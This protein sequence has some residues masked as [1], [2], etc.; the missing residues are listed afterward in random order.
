MTI[1][2]NG[3]GH[4]YNRAQHTHRERKRE[5]ARKWAKDRKN[6]MQKRTYQKNNTQRQKDVRGWCW[7]CVSGFFLN[8]IVYGVC[9][10]VHGARNLRIHTHTE[11]EGR[12]LC[13][14]QREWEQATSI[15]LH[16]YIPKR[17][18]FTVFVRFGWLCHFFFTFS[19]ATACCF[20][21]L[22]NLTYN[23]TQVYTQVAFHRVLVCAIDGAHNSNSVINVAVI[24]HD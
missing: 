4:I 20:S 9:C 22:R 1:T 16:V 19:R 3:N 17:P 2:N 14:V 8:R 12:I 5:T 13:V 10:F 7:V 15:N 18:K 11:R 21:F 6:G 23:T 24:G